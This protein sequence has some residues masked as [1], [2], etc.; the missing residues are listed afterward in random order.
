MIAPLC[1][2]IRLERAVIGRWR[3]LN[4]WRKMCWIAERLAIIRECQR[5]VLRGIEIDET[6]K[7]ITMLSAQERQYLS[8]ARI[9]DHNR[10]REFQ[11]FHRLQYIVRRALH[12][13]SRVWLVCSTEP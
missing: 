4:R 3:R 7:P 1:H 8:A 5:R 11:G 6:A 13:V 12:T 2:A 10:L 9:S